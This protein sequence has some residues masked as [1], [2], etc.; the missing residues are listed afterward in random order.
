MRILT[1]IITIHVIIPICDLFSTV[2]VH[3]SISFCS[4]LGLEISFIYWPMLGVNRYVIFKINFTI[5]IKVIIIIVIK[6]GHH[7]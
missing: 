5:I 4:H 1:I 2:Q 3:R 6:Q 7:L